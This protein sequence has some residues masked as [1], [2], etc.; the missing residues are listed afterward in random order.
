MKNESF[1]KG[2]DVSVAPDTPGQQLGS[3]G[4]SK[5]DDKVYHF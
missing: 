1:S 4:A 2:K 5:G 3:S